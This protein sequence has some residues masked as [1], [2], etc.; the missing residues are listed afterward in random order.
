MGA[1]LYFKTNKERAM[2]VA[3]YLEFNKTN[4]ELGDEGIFINTQEAVVWAEENNPGS[5]DYLTQ[6][7]GKGDIKVSGVECRGKN[8]L[9]PEEILEKQTLVLEDLNKRYEMKYF[10]NSCALTLEEHYFTMEQMKRFTQNGKLLS[11]KTSTSDRARE[12]YETYYAAFSE[13]EIELF[14]ISII[15]DRDSV[16][17]DGLWREVEFISYRNQYRLKFMSGSKF[18]ND[19]IDDVKEHIEGHRK[20]VP[21]IRFDGS[22]IDVEA[23]IIDNGTLIYLETIGQEYMVKSITSVLMQGNVKMNDKTIDATF[24]HFSINKAGNRRKMTSL[25]DG[26]AHAILYHSPSIKDTNF[27]VLV[28]RD[29][30]ELLTL[31]SAWL[32]KSQPLPYPKELEVEIYTKLHD[33]G[34]LEELKSL[35]IKAVKVDLSVL[36]EEC[37][38]LQEIILEVCREHNLIDVDAKPLKQKAPLPTSPLLTQKQVQKIYD[39]LSSMPKTYELEELDIKP[40]GLKLFNSNMTLYVTEVDL[41]SPDDEF[42]DMYIQCFGY[43]ENLSDTSCNE[44]GYINIG[45]YIRHGYEMDLYFEDKHIDGNGNVDTKSALER[46]A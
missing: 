2:E 32:E 15:R 11:G 37:H 25:G 22:T 39:T 44:W 41:G 43:V 26:L 40:V 46:A 5:V 38:D 16:L 30:D 1:Y 10:A 24:S 27:S 17:I 4:K 34:V 33:R 36:E 29:T 9:A 13:P 20:H 19:I 12:L 21:K 3:E 6:Q 8:G 18:I 31:F 14:D 7:I 42:T 23:Y 35:N 28:G 45:E